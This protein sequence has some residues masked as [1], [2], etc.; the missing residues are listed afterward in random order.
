MVHSSLLNTPGRGRPRSVNAP[1]LLGAVCAVA[2]ITGAGPVTHKASA[3]AGVPR[4]SQ[5]A[6]NAEVYLVPLTVRGDTVKIGVP[7]NLTRREGYDNQ[8]AFAPDS[9][10]FFYTSTRGDG[11]ADIY[12]FDLSSGLSSPILRS[13]V[14]SEYSAMPGADGKTVT[15]VRVEADSTQRLWQ[16]PLDGSA[17]KLLFPNIKPVGYFAEAND[18]TWGL[19][20]LGSPA[21]LQL[22][23]TRTGT[24]QVIASD[25]GRSIHRIP[26][27]RMLSFVQKGSAP[28]RVM[29]LDPDTRRVTPL[30]DLP[31]GSEDVTWVDSTTLITGSDTRLLMWKRGTSGWQTLGDVGFAHLR[32]I[33][34]L[35]VSPNRQWLAMVADAVPRTAAD[36]SQSEAAKY[37]DRINPEDVRRDIYILAADSMEGRGTGTRG[38][39]RA[40]RFLESQYK[41]AGL[42]PA[43]DSGTYRQN[44]PLRKVAMPNAPGG[45]TRMA[46]V[47]TWEE[48]NAL[49]TDERVL[50]QNITGI[51]RG[52][53]P[54]L[55][56]EVLL[57]TAHYDHL[58]I[59]RPVNGDSIYNGADD[60]ASGNVALLEVARALR[61]GPRP[62]RTIVFVSITG[63]EVGG[64]GTQWYLQHPVLPLEKT[65]LDL[66]I[67]MIA[68]ADSLAGGV[69]KAWLTGYERSTMGDI[70]ADNGIPLVP[71]PRPGQSFFS[72]SDNVAFARIG[73]PAHSLSSFNLETPYHEPD[74]EPSVVNVDHMAQVIAATVRAVRILAD[75]DKPVWHPGGQPEAPRRR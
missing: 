39:E 72:R 21:T 5:P 42:E 28:W 25:I 74:D 31:S 73:I 60:D 23:N 8:P 71:D 43:G 57:V 49:P 16:I 2:L 32:R 46:I 35:A 58:G 56:D 59:S 15:V 11:Q 75:G 6:P 36:A 68:N 50:T 18:S 19:F 37:V 29:Q 10:S 45:R 61:N 66:N 48:W 64:F 1:R 12:R 4:T 67:E 3:Q 30:V 55:K 9:R 41:A 24:A 40:A 63:E 13:S 14:E 65:V 38:M 33:S 52:S 70:L 62:R 34:R 27:S 54:V 7:A 69:G 47:P 44:I 22:A 20:V 51:L 26:G 53:D 17:P